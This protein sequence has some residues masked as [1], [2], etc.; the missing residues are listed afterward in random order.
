MKTT[1]AFICRGQGLQH[2]G[3][4]LFGLRN[5]AKGNFFEVIQ[6]LL[7]VSELHVEENYRPKRR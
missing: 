3:M 5:C 2:I 4:G 6:K 7:P 1:L